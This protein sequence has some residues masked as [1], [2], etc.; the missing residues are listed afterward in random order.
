MRP[1]HVLSALIVL[2]YSHS[3]AAQTPSPP[4]E[5]IRLI[6]GSGLVG[7]VTSTGGGKIHMYVDGV[8]DV[9]I[10]SAA[11]ASRSPVPPPPPPPSPWSG[12]M[13]GSMTH[14][15]TVAPGLA[16]STLGAQVTLGIARMGAR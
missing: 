12:T 3:A 4:P 5:V 9:V 15:S 8:G 6:G 14:I 7:R 10:D 13:T 16:G 11:V 1:S 2:G